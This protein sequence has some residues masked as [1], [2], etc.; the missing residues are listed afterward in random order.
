MLNDLD[1]MELWPQ[2]RKT[3]NR[4]CAQADTCGNPVTGIQL[5]LCK[6]HRSASSTSNEG[7]ETFWRQDIKLIQLKPGL[8]FCV[9]AWRGFGVYSVTEHS[10][11]CLEGTCCSAVH[12]QATRGL[13][14]CLYGS[15]QSNVRILGF[16]VVR[17]EIMATKLERLWYWTTNVVTLNVE[18]Q[19]K[20]FAKVACLSPGPFWFMLLTQKHKP[21]L[22]H[23]KIKPV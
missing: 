22:L 14:L 3:D 19:V 1:Q 21:G 9:A 6:G 12:S 20:T 11:F 10:K 23:Q 5:F 15:W 2:W 4:S 8:C 18:P 17:E 7:S 13:W 16:L